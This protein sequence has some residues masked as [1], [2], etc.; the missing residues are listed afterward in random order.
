[1]NRALWAAT[2]GGYLAEDHP[3]GAGRLR[4]TRRSRRFFLDHVTGRGTIPS[5][6]V[7]RQPYGVLRH[8]R[9]RP[10]AGERGRSRMDRLHRDAPQR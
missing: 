4:S 2:I 8:Q 5:V 1:M 7:G 6:R 3:V 9:A 10:L